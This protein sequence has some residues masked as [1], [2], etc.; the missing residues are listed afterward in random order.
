[1]HLLS[2]DYMPGAVQN[3]SQDPVSRHH[4]DLHF[5]ETERRL[6]G[7]APDATTSNGGDLN[8]GLGTPEPSPFT[9]TLHPVLCGLP[10]QMPLLRFL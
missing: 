3:A 5:K 7:E 6:G 9:Y 4:R 8:P 2:T 10:T 1:M